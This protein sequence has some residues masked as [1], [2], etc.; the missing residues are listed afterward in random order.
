LPGNPTTAIEKVRLMETLKQRVD[1][2]EKWTGVKG[3]LLVVED[4]ELAAAVEEGLYHITQEAL[5]NT[6]KHAAATSVMVHI[7][8]EGE[9]VELE[10][11]DDSIGF[12]PEAVNDEGAWAC[13]TCVN[14]P[15]G[16]GDIAGGFS[17][18]AGNDSERE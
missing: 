15:R 12:D 1:A 10:V 7:R 2:V 8:A 17:A 6:L 14:A 16:W 5:N 13:S 18:G 9:R 11:V 3:H 4:V